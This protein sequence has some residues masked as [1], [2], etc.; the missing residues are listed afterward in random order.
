MAGSE[1]FQN[2]RTFLKNG[3]I[4][5]LVARLGLTIRKQQI[6]RGGTAGLFLLARQGK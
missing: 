6:L 5:P 1:H 2:Y 3:G 4:P